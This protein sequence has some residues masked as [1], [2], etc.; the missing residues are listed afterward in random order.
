MVV[1]R[2]VL[3]AQQEAS[4][5]EALIAWV[6]HLLDERALELLKRNHQ[7]R[8]RAALQQWR[9]G[10]RATVNARATVATLQNTARLLRTKQ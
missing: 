6:A 9:S 1:L 5:R 8:K 2:S 7:T 3:V 4:Q 10:V